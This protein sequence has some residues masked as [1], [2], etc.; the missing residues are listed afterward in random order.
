MFAKIDLS[1]G[2]WRMLVRESNKW[3][4]AYVLPGAAGDPL[5]LIIPHALQMGW[6]ESPGY[7][8][9]TTKTGRDIMQAFID[10]GTGSRLVHVPRRSCPPPEFSLG[11]QA[12]ADVGRLRRR[13]HSSRRRK[14][15]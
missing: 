4:F 9:P 11:G 2:F 5:R 1:D 15:G 13:L 8:C 12:M 14:P 6:T 3:N 7:F 10:R